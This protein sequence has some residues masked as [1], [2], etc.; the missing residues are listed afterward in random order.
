MTMPPSIGRGMPAPAPRPGP[1][2][3]KPLP[4]PSVQQTAILEHVQS[5]KVG[6]Q[7]GVVAAAGSG[8]TTTIRMVDGAVRRLG[9]SLSV[10]AFNKHIQLEMQ[11]HGLESSTMHSVG[12]RLLNAR[13]PHLAPDFQ[14]GGL[15]NYAF[16]LTPA[17]SASGLSSRDLVSVFNEARLAGMIPMGFP[18]HGVCGLQADRLEHW[19]KV[20]GRTGR[21]KVL[22]LAKDPQS[23]RAKV[24]AGEVTEMLIRSLQLAGRCD[25]TD[26]IYRAVAYQWAP[27][28]APDVVAVDEFQDITPLDS[29]LVQ[30]VGGRSRLLVVGDPS[31]AIYGFRGTSPEHFN[32]VVAKGARLPLTVTRRCCRAVVD[33]VRAGGFEDIIARDDAP[34]G[35]V[36]TRVFD[37]AVDRAEW[38]GREAVP[39]DLVICRSNGE[40]LA[41]SAE[42]IALGTPVEVKL[43][44][45]GESPGQSFKKFFG[46]FDGAAPESYWPVRDRWMDDAEG[47]LRALMAAGK[48]EDAE[49]LADA[50][51]M[52]ELIE[53]TVRKSRAADLNSD[54]L[55]TVAAAVTKLFQTRTTKDRVRI[56]TI[57]R[58]KGLEPADGR[59]VF[60]LTKYPHDVMDA[61]TG[62][63]RVDPSRECEEDRVSYVAATR[64][65]D[66]LYIAHLSGYGGGRGRLMQMFQALQAS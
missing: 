7:A 15:K 52:L 58:A 10:Y 39:G 17:E 56:S 41:V 49:E 6:D 11:S 35:A 20:F 44:D 13:A 47:R 8:K 53:A 37:A 21:R 61:E 60:W 54:S 62:L 18:G 64:A 45:G 66:L 48:D 3:A 22:V 33:F 24:A 29:A 32:R 34:E 65:K 25:Y 51:E 14:A 57:H 1:S 12:W 28:S 5:M 59:T 46:V 4:A 19:A 43:G 36:R 42:L 63:R 30:L 23:P 50:G 27:A 55:G 26:Q 31:Q 40:L 9:W 2:K 38:V 16:E